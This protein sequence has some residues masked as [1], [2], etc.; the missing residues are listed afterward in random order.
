MMFNFLSGNVGR[1]YVGLMGGLI[2]CAALVHMQ[3]DR[4][5]VANTAVVSGCVLIALG[6][7]V[8][9]FRRVRWKHGSV[10]LQD[11]EIAKASAA[12]DISEQQRA[13]EVPMLAD[14]AAAG[15][16]ARRRSHAISIS[17]DNAIDATR[18]Y[19]ATLAL[20]AVFKDAAVRNPDFKDCE[21]RLYMYDSLRERLVAVLSTEEQEGAA[22]Q[23]KSGEGV[24]GV[25]YEQEKYVVAVDAETHDDTFNLDEEAQRTHADLREVAAIPVLSASRDV[26]GVLS[27]SNDTQTRILNTE[28]GYRVHTRVAVAAARIIVDLLG[29]AQDDNHK[30]TFTI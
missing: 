30:S 20:A 25:A 18:S 7:L 11:P 2:T 23:W 17:K 22:R 9:W 8:P 16:V 5:T 27:V 1:V 6:G 13:S 24:T 3:A 14:E 21:F 4:N 15:G 29:W 10:D 12:L 19:V 26:I 28:A